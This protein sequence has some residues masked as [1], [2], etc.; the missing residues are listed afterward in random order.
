MHAVKLCLRHWPITVWAWWVRLLFLTCC[1]QLGARFAHHSF[2]LSRVS[3]IHLWAILWSHQHCSIAESWC[4]QS[5]TTALNHC[6]CQNGH[7]IYG[8]RNTTLTITVSYTIHAV[9]QRIS[10]I[11]T[12]SNAQ[13]AVPS[14]PVQQLRC[15]LYDTHNL[16]INTT[17]YVVFHPQYD[18]FPCH[19]HSIHELV[20]ILKIKC[21]QINKLKFTHVIRKMRMTIQITPRNSTTILTYCFNC[22]S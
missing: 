2:Y 21:I 16:A 19:Y 5:S 9:V 7:N 1:W 6:W 22:H 8:D 11:T 12:L 10:C 3:W 4:L 15:L 20:E 13:Q 14:I 18:Y 17:L